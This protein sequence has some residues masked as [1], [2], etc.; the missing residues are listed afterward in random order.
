MNDIK[1]LS[2][3]DGDVNIVL[4]RYRQDVEKCSR[5]IYLKSLEGYIANDRI[6]QKKISPYRARK[7]HP[8]N[9]W[10]FLVTRMG[11]EPMNA[12]VRGW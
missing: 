12:S 1:S 6:S 7:N 11:F 3:S 8:L 4:C 2:H 10:F 9:G 5:G